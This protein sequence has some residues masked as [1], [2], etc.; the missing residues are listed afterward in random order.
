M[1][2]TA[3]ESVPLQTIDGYLAGL[4]AKT[5]AS[6]S[7]VVNCGFDSPVMISDFDA[8]KRRF[9]CLRTLRQNVEANNDNYF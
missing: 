6:V 7:L 8:G 3:P 9:S 5:L 2:I 1:P 4:D